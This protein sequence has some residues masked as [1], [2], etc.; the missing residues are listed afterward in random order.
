[1][2]FVAPGA[3]G[4]SER[5]VLRCL[6]V[7]SAVGSCVL[8]GPAS[9][10]A[11]VQPTYTA[12]ATPFTLT[13]NNK[14]ERL[15]GQI[16]GYVGPGGRLSY[17]L[18]SG[19]RHTVTNL[20][21]T[22]RGV[23]E[24]TYV[25][26][27]DEPGRRASVVV[28]QTDRG[29]RI[30]TR[31]QPDDGIV[32]IYEA[33]S[34]F[35]EHF[36]GS[37]ERR[38]VDLLHKAVQLK[39]AHSCRNYAL[40]PFYIS[41]GGYGLW[42]DTTRTGSFA[43]AIEDP[44]ES[45]ECARWGINTCPAVTAGDRVQL[46]FHDNRLSYELYAGTPA[47]VLEAY[48]RETGRPALPPPAQFGL[49]KWRDKNSSF[50]E[51]KED[52]LQF[53][54]AGVPLHTMLVDNPWESGGCQGSLT[55]GS[56]LGSAPDLMAWLRQ[57]RIE[58]WAWISPLV[59]YG[60][61]LGYDEARLLPHSPTHGIVDLT[62]PADVALFKSKLR[63]L[64]GLGVRGVKV[65]RGDD[66]DIEAQPVSNDNSIG[67]HNRYPL[68]LAQAVTDVLREQLGTNYSTIFRSSYAGGQAIQHGLWAGDQS[69]TWAGLL[70]STRMAQS[71]G[72]SGFPIWGS[73]I[74]GYE[75]EAGEP[76]LS[77]ELFVRWSQFGAISPV[78][79]VGGAGQNATPWEFGA[80]T[81]ELL[82]RSATLHY[83]LFPYLYQLARGAARTGEPILR[84]LG[85]V[86]PDVSEAWYHD[87][88]LMVGPSLVA[89]VVTEPLG[90]TVDTRRPM[91]VWLPEG[92]WIDLFTGRVVRGGDVSRQTSLADFPLYL[93]QGNAI[94][95]NFRAPNV[96]SSSWRINDLD[97]PDRIGFLY[98]PLAGRRAT[99][100][101][102]ATTFTARA[103]SDAI[104]LVLSRPRRETA[105]RLVG[106]RTICRATLGDK[107]LRRVGSAA[108]LRGRA[109]GWTSRR[110]E[111]VLKL[112]GVPARHELKLIFCK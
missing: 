16:G 19:A 33:L 102:G 41:S 57:R 70:D 37:G 51:V 74:G 103:G 46:C 3:R 14:G 105:V 49:V 23:A 89:Q 84:P 45:F 94:A 32:R 24:T 69:Q 79:E 96:W 11:V 44:F 104:T 31:F 58:I 106:A 42:V 60:C 52:V 68:R 5:R 62:R 93:R 22:R 18:A 90:A 82:R 109:L 95:Y 27:T 98:A 39:V 111:S 64:I 112:H 80:Q 55:F 30:E 9:A 107:V 43:F 88:E 83:E 53:E 76:Q 40:T 7:A 85:F 81:M 20:L 15:T 12:S 17:E 99:A 75:N 2:T 29:L 108:G 56:E 73:D 8:S 97:R 10:S 91:R 66:V 21:E 4:Q 54:R 63:R 13:F 6:L 72:V 78:M 101:A 35:D 87:T 77:A 65:D 25:V 48:T 36:L 1:M 28:K 47:Q 71:A 38:T 61:G 50:G 67:E 100:R 110:G 92:G 59:R 34:V 86:F 26:A